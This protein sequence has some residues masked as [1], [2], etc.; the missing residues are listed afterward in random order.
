MYYEIQAMLVFL[1]S[2]H[3]TSNMLNH[4]GLGQEVVWLVFAKEVLIQSK[5]LFTM[6]CHLLL[7]K[8]GSA[9]QNCRA[10]IKQD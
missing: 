4:L 2:N 8:T 5:F 9:L 10:K 6:K 3:L 1:A 7:I